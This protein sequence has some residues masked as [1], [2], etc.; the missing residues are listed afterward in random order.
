MWG[1]FGRESEEHARR[2]DRAT[3]EY[4]R[5]VCECEWV[6]VC[7]CVSL[8]GSMIHSSFPLG[9]PL[10]LFA[11]ACVELQKELRNRGYF[12]E[13]QSLSGT[14]AHRKAT[15]IALSLCLS[16]ILFSVC[17]LQKISCAEGWQQPHQG[18]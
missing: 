18:W 10:I 15:A 13:G 2:R 1:N 9:V 7:V 5:G 3:N 12:E 8:S 4:K 17:F 14:Q 11:V 6:S 16:H